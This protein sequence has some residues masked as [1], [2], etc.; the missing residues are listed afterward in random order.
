MVIDTP[1]PVIPARSWEVPLGKG[2]N[3][4]ATALIAMAAGI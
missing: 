2:W 4:G 1:T 3:L